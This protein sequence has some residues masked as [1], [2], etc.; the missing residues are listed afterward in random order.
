ELVEALL[1]SLD[2]ALAGGHQYPQHLHLTPL[3]G[4]TQVSTAECF[5]RHPNRVQLVRLASRSARTALGMVAFVD[6]FALGAQV[7]GQA[8]SV[9][10]GALHHPGPLPTQLLGPAQQPGISLG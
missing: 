3:L 5:L 8:G 10:A 4:P 7:R 1:L 9:A 6:E 2:C